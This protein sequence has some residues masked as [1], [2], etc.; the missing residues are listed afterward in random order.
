MSELRDRLDRESERISLAPGADV[1][2]WERRHRL[3]R[4]RRVSALALGAIV[5]LLVIVVSLHGLVVS[6]DGRS[7]APP[8]STGGY[9]EIAGTYTTRL[10]EDLVVAGQRLGGPYELRLLETGSLLLSVPPDFEQAVGSVVFRLSGNIFTTNAF[11]NYSCPG[12]VGTYRWSLDGDALRLVPL[13]EPCELRGAVLST[14]P[15]QVAGVG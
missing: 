8:G 6:G 5:A 13:D 12:T 4:R 3:E 11:A 15:W 14:R 1:R 10:P 2:L 9:A 7:P